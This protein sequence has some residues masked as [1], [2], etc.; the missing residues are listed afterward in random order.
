MQAYE[1]LWKKNA[2]KFDDMSNLS[3]DLRKNWEKIFALDA[4]TVDKIQYSSDGTLKT[5]FPDA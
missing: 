3:L 4:I 2:R 1:W 5:R